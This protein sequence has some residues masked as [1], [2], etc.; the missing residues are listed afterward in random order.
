MSE[1]PIRTYGEFWPY[2]VNAHRHPLTR[3][4]HFIGTSLA[5]FCLVAVVVGMIDS[6]FLLAVPVIAYG[7]AWAAHFIVEKNTPATFGHPLWSLV[8]DVRM[9]GLMCVGRMAKEVERTGL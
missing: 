8:S 4:L 6:W 9:I 7:F 3:A 5:I 1:Q 2:Y